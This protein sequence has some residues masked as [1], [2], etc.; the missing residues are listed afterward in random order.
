MESLFLGQITPKEMG[1]VTSV[2][3]YN[4]TGGTTTFGSSCLNYVCFRATFFQMQWWRIYRSR[5]IRVQLV[6]HTV[7]LLL[8]ENIFPWAPISC[9]FLP[10]STFPSGEG[11][12]GL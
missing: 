4:M 11:G 9:S 8:L 12:R 5:W 3:R 10:A 1:T 2:L 7:R 6:V